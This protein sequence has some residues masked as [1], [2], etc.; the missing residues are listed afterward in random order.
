M[1][2]GVAV[3][4]LKKAFGARIVPAYMSGIQAG[5][6]AMFVGPMNRLVKAQA[7][8]YYLDAIF[9]EDKLTRWINLGAAILL[10]LIIGG[11]L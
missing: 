10:A 8:N 11:A 5:E 1:G 4:A 3:L 7:R 2:F 9:G 6:P